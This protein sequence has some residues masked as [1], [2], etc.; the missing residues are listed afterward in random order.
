MA[1]DGM[2]E[3]TPISPIARRDYVPGALKAIGGH[4]G[5]GVAVF[6]RDSN[7]AWLSERYSEGPIGASPEHALRDYGVGAQILLDLGVREM[8]LLTTREVRPAALDGYSLKIVGWRPV[9]GEA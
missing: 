1:G 5:A 9:T 8:I 7:P 4:D 2:T 6:L 3:D